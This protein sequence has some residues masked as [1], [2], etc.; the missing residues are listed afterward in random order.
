MGAS[1]TMHPPSTSIRRRSSG[2]RQRLRSR[3]SKADA[4]GGLGT[5][6]APQHQERPLSLVLALTGQMKQVLSGANGR[7]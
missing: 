4:S 1:G 6:A 2:V 5:T 3:E 7:D